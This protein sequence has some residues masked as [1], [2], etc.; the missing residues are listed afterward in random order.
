MSALLKML[1]GAVLFLILGIVGNMDF[2]DALIE[3][4]RY[5]DMVCAGS[6][7]DYKKLSPECE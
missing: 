1:L 4:R 3:E 6:W 2:E 5:A 7:P